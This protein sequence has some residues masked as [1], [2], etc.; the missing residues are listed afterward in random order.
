MY[1]ISMSYKIAPLQIREKF[2]FLPEE[3]QIFRKQLIGSKQ[4]KSLVIL[5]T[6][7]RSELYFTGEKEALGIVEQALALHKKIPLS[8]VRRLV[9]IFE[10][11]KAIT[12]L[13]RVT[14]GLDSM[15]AGADEILGQVKK[16]YQ[17]ALESH[18]TDT[19]LNIIFQGAISS[20]RKI[21]EATGLSKTAVSIGTLVAHEIFQ[22][23]K[24]NKLEKKKVLIIGMTGKMGT[25]IMR[26]IYQ[27]KEIEVIGTVRQHGY[28]CCSVPK[29]VCMINYHE[30]YSYINEAD[31]IISATASPHYTLTFDKLCEVMTQSKNR[32]FIDLAVPADID[33]SMSNMANVKLIDIDH[34]NTLSKKNNV[35][36]VRALEQGN[37]LLEDEVKE[38]L[39]KIYFNSLIKEQ[40]FLSK[41]Q[42]Q[43]SM[44]ELLVM[45]REVS[46]HQTLEMLYDLVN[47]LE[48]LSIGEQKKEI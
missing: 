28:E 29:K 19:M 4:I 36:K 37:L 9:M 34:F 22:F 24:K 31:I 43:K 26:N 12:H 23:E 5:S 33:K 10:G 20:A 42:E 41:L 46:D 30:R 47:K 2:A 38:I 3:E 27:H 7:N 48:D 17:N 8:E 6:C 14:S 44:K 39:K 1:C 13:Y 32:L 25:I 18:T 11:E 45:I 40:A 15:V 35:L 21:K 16:A